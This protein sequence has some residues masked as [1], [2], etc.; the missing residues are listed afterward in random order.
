QQLGDIH[1]VEALL[2]GNQP[3]VRS[4]ARGVVAAAVGAVGNLAPVPQHGLAVGASPGLDRLPHHRPNVV[5]RRPTRSKGGTARAAN[6]ECRCKR[7]KR[8]KTHAP[9]W[10][11][12]HPARSS[13]GKRRVVDGEGS[14]GGGVV[15]VELLHDIRA[16]LLDR[17]YAQGEAA[18]DFTVAPSCSDQFENLPFTWREHIGRR[19]GAGLP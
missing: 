2:E 3:A 18:G 7:S 14:E 17:L 9:S 10:S 11:D 5:F 15:Q 19:T 4:D 12:A 16:V 8:A 6:E 13:R 1:I